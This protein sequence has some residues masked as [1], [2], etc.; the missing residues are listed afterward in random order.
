MGLGDNT[1][2]GSWIVSRDNKSEDQE[3]PA[4]EIST[5]QAEV[6]DTEPGHGPPSER[7]CLDQ[8]LCRFRRLSTPEEDSADTRERKGEPSKT[9][10]GMCRY[11]CGVGLLL[12]YTS[13]EERLEGYHSWSCRRCLRRRSGG[14]GGI[15]SS[16][17]RSGRH[18]RHL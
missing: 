15:F 6:G 8:R 11:H 5:L 10:G 4:P 9:P 2:G 3:P 17:S 1:G 12:T 16:K 14:L 13:C 18:L 7:F